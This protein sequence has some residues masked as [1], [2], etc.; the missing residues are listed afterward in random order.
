MCLWLA[1]RGLQ[2]I[3]IDPLM[4]F[5]S[6][7]IHCQV[8]L[9]CSQQLI[10]LGVGSVGTMMSPGGD[11]HRGSPSPNLAPVAEGGQSRSSSPAP[12]TIGASAV[13]RGLVTE[14]PLVQLYKRAAT[15]EDAAS[16]SEEHCRALDGR[17]RVR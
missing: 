3:R 13:A 9:D 11:V 8:L 4:S 6:S 17:M 15:V 5:S 2:Q 16:R 14:P 1:H 7:H 12:F 10:S